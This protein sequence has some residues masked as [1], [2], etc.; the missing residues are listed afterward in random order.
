MKSR[1]YVMKVNCVALSGRV[2]FPRHA[3]MERKL[4]L[5]Y[6]FEKP[7]IKDAVASH[8]HHSYL[9]FPPCEATMRLL[10]YYRRE[11]H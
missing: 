9:L 4:Y 8:Q 10:F 1:L 5:Q 3:L 7:Y 6:F 2:R 11:L